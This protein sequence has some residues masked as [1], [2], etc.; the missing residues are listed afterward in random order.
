MSFKV[1]A[2]P[3]FERQLKRLARKHASLGADLA[4]LIKTLE[5]DPTTGVALGKDCY[6][7]RLAITSKGVGKSGGARV[8][9]TI[10]VTAE[11]VVLLAIYDK[12][13]QSTISDAEIDKL[14]GA[15]E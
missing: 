15:V 8:I 6:K 7:I 4:A 11:T 9:T 5:A 1:I 10:V 13:D 2:I 12:S 14:L 3:P